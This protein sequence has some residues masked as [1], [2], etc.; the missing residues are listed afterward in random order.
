MSTYK[1]N[2]QWRMVSNLD[3]I[4]EIIREGGHPSWPGLTS[5]D[6]IISITWVESLHGYT[7]TWK[8]REWEGNSDAI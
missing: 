5:A 3:H 4:T 8:V 6:Q 1:I 7:V 2:L